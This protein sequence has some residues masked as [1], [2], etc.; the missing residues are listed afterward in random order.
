[1]ISDSPQ[2]T[3]VKETLDNLIHSAAQANL[4]VLD[5]LYHDDMKINMLD[6][7]KQ[8]H[9]MDKRGF[10]DFLRESTASGHTPSTWAQYHL[11]EADD[12][13]G[14]VIISRK[15]NLMG[16]EKIITLSI[17]FVFESGRW[18]ISREVIFTS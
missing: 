2:A 9:V 16:D 4:E 11:V 14:H 18:Q 10:I 8:L 12:K 1:M 5:T 3:Q 6:A 15:A 17:D 7:N 13:K